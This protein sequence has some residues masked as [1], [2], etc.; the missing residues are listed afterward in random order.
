[1][2]HLVIIRHAKSSWG[3]ALLEDFDRPLND[4]GKRDA[5]IMAKRLLEKKLSPDLLITSPAKRAVATCNEFA[6]VFDVEKNKIKKEPQLYHASESTILKIVNNLDDTYNVVFLFG[7]NPG[8][9]DF[10]NDISNLVIGNIPTTGIVVLEISS[11][12]K[13]GKEKAK[14]ICFDYPG[15]E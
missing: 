6:E 7:H 9:T 2:K 12:K 15:N 13:L 10:V 8:L 14:A 5:P 1:M 4:R 3:N 11:W